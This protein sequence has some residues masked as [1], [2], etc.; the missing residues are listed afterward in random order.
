MERGTNKNKVPE[1]RVGCG[2]N[3]VKASVAI[4]DE[5]SPVGKS[6][7]VLWLL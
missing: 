5:I 3:R 1:A 7:R 2:R 6:C 4:V